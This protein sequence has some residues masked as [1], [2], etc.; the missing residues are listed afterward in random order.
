[1]PFAFERATSLELIDQGRNSRIQ[2]EK[3]GIHS[4]SPVNLAPVLPE[5]VLDPI[6]VLLLSLGG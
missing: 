5:P 4:G 6:I 1:M 3:Q 2:L